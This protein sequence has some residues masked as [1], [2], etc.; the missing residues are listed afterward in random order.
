MDE[1]YEKYTNHETIIVDMGKKYSIYIKDDELAQWIDM[2]VRSGRYRN[3]SHLFEEA[4][5]ELREEI[6]KEKAINI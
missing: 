4:A 6:K 3:P 1:K 5:K 2:Q